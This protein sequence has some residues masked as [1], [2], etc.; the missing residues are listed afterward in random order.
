[1]RFQAADRLHLAHETIARVCLGLQ[2]CP[3]DFQGNRFPQRRMAGA[4]DNSHPA[5]IKAFD[6]FVAAE[7]GARFQRLAQRASRAFG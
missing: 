7:N 2:H 4:V 6:D 5:T 3:D 1:M